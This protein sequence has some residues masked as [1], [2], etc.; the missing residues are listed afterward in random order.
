MPFHYPVAFYDSAIADKVMWNDTIASL[1]VTYSSE[2][3]AISESG[4]GVG[5]PR[6][7]RPR[8]SQTDV[9]RPYRCPFS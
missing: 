5:V 1:R 6:V 3:G 2:L 9:R 4:H 7:R 8:S